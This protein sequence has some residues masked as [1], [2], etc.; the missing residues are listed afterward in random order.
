M[1]SSAASNNQLLMDL[2]DAV[3]VYAKSCGTGRTARGVNG[4]RGGRGAGSPGGGRGP[5]GEPIRPDI[6]GA[7][8]NRDI[9]DE[10]VRKNF[11]KSLR[12]Q[13]FTDEEIRAALA[14]AYN[15]SRLG[16][17]EEASYANTSND[18]IRSIFSSTRSLSDAELNALKADRTAFYNYVYGPNNAVG[19]GLGN[20]LEGDGAAYAGRGTI[21]LTG[22]GNY[23]KYGRLAGYGD[24]LVRQPELMVADPEISTAVTAAYLRDRYRDRGDGTLGNMRWAVA[25]SQRGYDL[26]IGKDRTV[27]DSIDQSWLE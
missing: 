17:R 25:G 3:I 21:Q 12:E 24:L 15:E 11:V 2:L 23:E 4:G 7:A 19:R 8:G 5:D 22:R 27:F 6:R 1:I 20:I 10:E 16:L 26:S 13:G 18:R 9:T 14:V